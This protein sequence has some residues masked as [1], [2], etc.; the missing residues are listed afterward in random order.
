MAIIDNDKHLLGEL[1]LPLPAPNRPVPGYVEQHPKVWWVAVKQ[2]LQQLSQ[3]FPD[4]TPQALAIDGTSSTLLLCD[5]DGEPLHPAL[6]YNDSRAIKQAE[7]L[8]KIAP[9]DSPV[10]SASS[11][12]AKAL[13]LA[14][15]FPSQG[16]AHLMHQADWLLGKLSGEPGVSDDNNCLKLGY[17]TING[18][19]P[20]WLEQL[21]IPQQWLP[22]V[23][24][25]GTTVGLIS[26]R[27][28][29][30]LNL[31]PQLKLVA[32]TTDSTAA[33][34]AAGISQ[35]GEA[36]TSLGSTLVLKVLSDRPVF[37]AE[38]GVYSHRIGD[39]WLVGGASN[40]GGAVL[41]QYFSDEQIQA[42]SQRVNPNKPTGLNYYPLPSMGERFPINDPQLQPRLTPRPASD[43]LFFQGI[44]EGIAQIECEGY[45]RLSE[46]GA[47]AANQI[48]SIGGGTANRGW[49]E[50]R[51]KLLGCPIQAAP[52]QQAA[53]GAALL[54]H[55]YNRKKMCYSSS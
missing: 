12:L 46:L 50:I 11:S 22:K 15:Q 8:S 54:A 31:P 39:L 36:V 27:I 33:T 7:I 19:W 53:Y 13:Y 2:L 29:N 20:E 25:P 16:Q 17:D 23:S 4:H 48:W 43:P 38:Y 14:G 32:G 21:P 52:H 9:T 18:C 37:A 49:L 44:L 5:A 6:M 30:E 41:K 26:P 51:E 34:L 42:Y 47:P 45:A 28:A 35:I 40:S 55:H 1:A 3:Q 24:P 10:I